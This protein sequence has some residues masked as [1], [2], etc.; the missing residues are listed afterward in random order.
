MGVGL[1]DG[2][3]HT[4]EQEWL[5]HSYSGFDNVSQV[6]APNTDLKSIVDNAETHSTIPPTSSTLPA[7][8]LKSSGGGEVPPNTN[9]SPERSILDRLTG[10]DGGERYQ[11]FPERMVRGAI[12]AMALPG[13]V[14]S[15]KV[16]PG[17]VQ[18]IER[19]TDLAGLMVGGPAP[20]ASRL[21]D[22]TLGSFAGVTSKTLDKNKLAEAQVMQHNG[23]SIDDIWEKTGFFKGADDR[24]KFEISPEKATLKDTAFEK[25]TIPNDPSVGG[26]NITYTLKDRRP[27]PANATPDEMS[28]YFNQKPLQLSEVLDHPE[29][30]K[31]YPSLKDIKVARL[32][33]FLEERG[34]IGQMDSQN[35]TMY[36][37][38]DLDPSFAKSVILHEVQHS[39][40]EAEGFAR[41]G[42]PQMFMHPNLSKAEEL[43]QKAIEQGGDPSSP[44]LLKAK[45]I[46]MDEKTKARDMYTRLMG[47]VEARNVQARMDYSD[48]TRL[49][50]PPDISESIPRDQQIRQ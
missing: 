6:E 23:A 30:F 3:S 44:A 20:V 42:T 18:E 32:P 14:L 19:A 29:L 13:D 25:N 21:A 38:G 27:L 22:G 15:G 7:D 28:A 4:D 9:A 40:Q 45:K 26:D 16:Q 41:G 10:L 1:S 46:I 33:K 50:V 34:T 5:A 36:L 47:E 11:T 39:I 17:S 37:R 31:A 2:S 35:N 24:W 43:Y 8:A 48:N 12:S 49:S